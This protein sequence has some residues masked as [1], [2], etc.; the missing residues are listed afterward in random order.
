[1][2]P[3]VFW[4]SGPWQGR[5]GILARPR[6]GDWLEDEI[7]SWGNLGVDVIVS[8]LTPDEETDLELLRERTLAEQQ[9]ISFISFPVLDRGIPASSSDAAELLNR[10]RNALESGQ[11]IAVHCRQGIGRSALVAAGALVASGI[12]PTNALKMVSVARGIPVP[13]T[14]QQKAWVEALPDV[15]AVAGR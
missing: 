9:G 4:I 6:G 12:D 2:T 1:M 8:L 5:I 15:I 3:K 14:P 10:L 7:A 13:E 11:T